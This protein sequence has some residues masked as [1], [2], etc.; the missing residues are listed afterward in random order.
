MISEMPYF[1][2]GTQSIYY[3]KMFVNVMKGMCPYIFSASLTKMFLLMIF[4]QVL[5]VLNAT[6]Q[7]HACV[8][9]EIP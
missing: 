1:C 9:N 6:N 2:V 3:S 8:I 4:A 7:F 5:I